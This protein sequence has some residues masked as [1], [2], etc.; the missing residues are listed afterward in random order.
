MPRTSE[1]YQRVPS[2]LLQLRE[3]P[4]PVV[5]RATIETL[6]R[7]SR[8][9]AIRILVHFGAIQSGRCLWL[10]RLELIHQLEQVQQ[11]SDYGADRARRRKIA[12]LASNLREH[13]AARQTVISAPK[14]TVTQLTDLPAGIELT[15]THLRIDFSERPE[16]LSK[17]L[18]VVKLLAHEAT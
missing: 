17:L 18:A 12:D 10:D 1:W 8:R 5:D 6:F 3:L 13:W 7:V 15:E 16:L 2:V 14:H 4:F 11:S 9:Q